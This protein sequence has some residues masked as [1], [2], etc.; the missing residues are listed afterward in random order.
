M[1]MISKCRA[2]AHAQHITPMLQLFTSPPHSHRHEL[3]SS[4]HPSRV[5]SEMHHPRRSNH[6]ITDTLWSHFQ[7]RP[8]SS[9]QKQPFLRRPTEHQSGTRGAM[10]CMAGEIKTQM[11]IN[12]RCNCYDYD[13]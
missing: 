8:T 3:S 9:Q 6:K 12:A 1:C 5:L 2:T 7:T 10:I 11:R 13:Y 4:P